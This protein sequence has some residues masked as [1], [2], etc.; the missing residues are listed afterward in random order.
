MNRKKQ[1]QRAKTKK[2]QRPTGRQGSRS[3]QKQ[4][5]GGSGRAQLTT[6]PSSVGMVLPRASFKRGGLAQ[7]LTDQDSGSSERVVGCDLFDLGVFTDSE[8]G[9][10]GFGT[11]GTTPPQFANLTPSLIS[12]RLQAIEEMY[13]WYAIRRLKVHFVPNVGS[14]SNG[15]AAFGIATDPELQVSFPTPSQQQVL[16]L[17]PA[18]VTP[19]WNLAT[20]EYVHRGTKL[21]ESYAASASDVEQKIQATLFVSGANA[22]ILNIRIMTVA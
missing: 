22:S 14:N 2:S 8:S 17:N 5:Q 6:A 10:F 12:T 15:S 20:I 3:K 11:N 16:E 4:P 9:E 1:G 19:I 18:V 21:W 7:T 13:Q